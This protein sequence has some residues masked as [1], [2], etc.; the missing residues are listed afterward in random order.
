MGLYG[1][2]SGDY[3]LQVVF[4]FISHVNA[5]QEKF[6]RT[7]CI[8]VIVLYVCAIELGL[9]DRIRLIDSGHACI[10]PIWECL[11]SIWLLV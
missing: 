7:S 11:D 3:C 1:N 6:V 2:N 9:Y 8:H 10:Q 4:Y 5:M